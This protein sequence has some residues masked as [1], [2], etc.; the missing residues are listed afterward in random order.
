MRCSRASADEKTLQVDRT[1][2]TAY[3]FTDSDLLIVHDFEMGSHLSTYDPWPY[4][5]I[6]IKDTA[7][8]TTLKTLTIINNF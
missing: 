6:A 5:A 2:C 4:T 3:C 7:R 1:D 8:K